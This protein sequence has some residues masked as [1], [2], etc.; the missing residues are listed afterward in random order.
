MG[1]NVDER[2]AILKVGIDHAVAIDIGTVDVKSPELPNI[3]WHK[4]SSAIED[5]LA[6]RFFLLDHLAS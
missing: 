4:K 1:I 5:A 2:A 6:T 3:V